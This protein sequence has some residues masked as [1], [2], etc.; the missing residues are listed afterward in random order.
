M[1]A[2]I[3]KTLILAAESMRVDHDASKCAKEAEVALVAQL[4]SAA[5]KIGKLEFELA[6]LKGSDVSAPTS[7]QLEITREKATHLNARL[8]KTQTML[9][10]TKKEINHVFPVVEDL[11]RVNL[12]LKS[13][14]FAK[15]EELIFMHAEVSCLK[16]IATKLK[17][18]EMDL[19]GVL[20]AN[21][22]LKKRTG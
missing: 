17:S 19:Q 3:H 8:S 14:C 18:K 12:E 13:A 21:E 9:E 10:A 1:I 2:T 5:E 16:E 11:E 15:D 6:I 7:L 20:S 22:N 4:R